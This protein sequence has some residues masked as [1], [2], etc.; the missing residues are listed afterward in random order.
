MKK[1]ILILAIFLSGCFGEKTQTTTSSTPRGASG[2][3]N[4]GI[5]GAIYGAMA[6]EKFQPAGPI[7]DTVMSELNNAAKPLPAPTA[8]QIESANKRV[9]VGVSGDK[10]AYELLL[11]KESEKIK[12]LQE[13]LRIAED[14]KIQSDATK[15]ASD[16]ANERKLLLTIFGI[17][18]GGL[19]AIG[20]VLLAFGLWLG[21]SALPGISL[22]SCGILIGSLAFVWG[23]TLFTVFATI[24]LGLIL[25]GGYK[26]IT[27]SIQHKKKLSDLILAK[28]TLSK[29]I[30]AVDEEKLDDKSPL[31]V[32]LRGKM[33]YDEKQMVKQ[34]RN[35]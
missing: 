33:D 22:L 34:V 3:L 13:K 8:E 29:V 16:R 26:Y 9:S 19:S 20:S 23:T 2:E 31:I 10:Q 21:R 12:Q 5:S 1:I 7:T 6:A 11:A 25:F 18:G 15:A 4:Q 28:D 30:T 17:V 27:D 35:E 24:A 14:V 32:N